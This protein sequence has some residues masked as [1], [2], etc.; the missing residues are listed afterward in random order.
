MM[1]IFRLIAPAAILLAGAAH[2]QQGD[3]R[4]SDE[5]IEFW[6]KHAIPLD[7]YVERGYGMSKPE[8]AESDEWCPQQPSTLSLTYAD[9]DVCRRLIEKMRE[10]GRIE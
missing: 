10:M 8:D 1:K 3:D 9:H 6:A 7:E 4:V 5:I 2:A